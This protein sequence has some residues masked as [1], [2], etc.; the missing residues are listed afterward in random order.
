MAFAV[1]EVARQF[2]RPENLAFL[3]AI[4]LAA[5]WLG[6]EHLLLLAALGLP[7]LF[8]AFGAFRFSLIDSIGA[9]RAV[10]RDT[11]VVRLS[12]ILRE[13]QTEGRSTACMVL[14]LDDMGDLVERYGHAA[15][16]EILNRCIERLQSALR[17]GDVVARLEHDSFG[18]GLSPVRQA[19]LE[20]VLQLAARLQSSL[21]NPI[22]LDA[23][24]LYV[25]ASIGFCLSSRVP[26]PGGSAILEAAEIAA[27]DALKNGPG[28]IRA[29]SAEMQRMRISRSEMRGEIESALDQGQIIPF[30]QPQ[31]ST[32]TGEISGFEAL[33]RWK[34]PKRGLVPPADFLPL[35]ERAGLSERLSETILFQSLTA[36][37]AWDAAEQHV[38]HVAVNFSR[39]QLRNPRLTDQLRWELDRF[40]LTPDRICVE[41]LETVVAET[42]NDVIVHN[43]AALSKMGCG[44]DLDDFGTGHASIANIRRFAVRRIK[45]DRSFVTQ[46]DTDQA[47]QRMVAAILSMAERLGLESLAEGVETAGEH[48]MLAQLGCGYIQ[49]FGLARPM[50][51]E[52]TVAWM[53]SYRARLT[54]H[55][56]IGRHAV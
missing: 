51:F 14:K 44:I 3:P 46:V 45:I 19:D 38:P 26:A 22:S 13:A 43:I 39:E 55:P 17:E 6:G 16:A 32:D 49:G 1:R 52:E 7:L 34:H 54:D 15:H 35:M 24:R 27:D 31:V 20:A 56:R 11:L 53:Q 5:Y 50:P 36:L 12:A 42:D 29:Y 25:T 23:A 37:T 33:A 41:I 48:T 2:R 9:G 40:G 30:F 18:I 21:A 8:L 10:E 47:Q 28:A 4:T